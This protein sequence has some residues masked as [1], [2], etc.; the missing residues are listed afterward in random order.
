MG[1][2]YHSID[3]A[4][5]TIDSKPSDKLFKIE[6]GRGRVGYGQLYV[7]QLHKTVVGINLLARS[8]GMTETGVNLFQRL[9]IKSKMD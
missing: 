6:M 8:E 5:G 2:N 3:K 7:K 9:C 4:V 1:G